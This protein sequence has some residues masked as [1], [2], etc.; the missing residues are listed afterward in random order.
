MEALP[1]SRAKREEGYPIL[2]Q[3]IRS[4]TESSEL[5]TSA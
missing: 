4:V 1:S 2:I 5:K 3:C